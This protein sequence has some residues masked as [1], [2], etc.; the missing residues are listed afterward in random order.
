MISRETILHPG[1]AAISAF[2][3]GAPYAFATAAPL[4][5]PTRR[6]VNVPRRGHENVTRTTY[7]FTARSMLPAGRETVK[8]AGE[9]GHTLDASRM[10][11]S[12]I[13]AAIVGKSVRSAPRLR[14]P[15]RAARF[16]SC[17]SRSYAPAGTRTGIAATLRFEFFVRTIGPPN[18]FE[19]P[20]RRSWYAAQSMHVCHPAP[21]GSCLLRR[22]APGTAGTDLHSTRL[23]RDFARCTSP[24]PQTRDNRSSRS[25]PT[26]GLPVEVWCD[27]P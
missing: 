25:L 3:T 2:F 16:A 22:A 13:T 12:S 27:V 26:E 20:A 9:P 6:W 24:L 10:S 8:S 23:Q 15:S 5:G 7:F 4:D 19:V 21:A 17:W 1:P 18:T 14:H 11:A